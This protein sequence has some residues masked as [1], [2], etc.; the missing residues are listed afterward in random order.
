MGAGHG[1]WLSDS[2]C[3]GF[4]GG[5]M[6]V[7]THLAALHFHHDC[8]DH[9]LGLITQRNSSTLKIL[10]ISFSQNV[11]DSSAKFIVNCQSLTE[12]DIIGTSLSGQV[13]RFSF[14]FSAKQCSEGYLEF[15][16][17]SVN[18]E[19]VK[20]QTANCKLQYRNLPPLHRDAFC[21]FLFRWIYYCYNSKSTGKETGKT[22]LCALCCTVYTFT[23]V[24]NHFLIKYSQSLPI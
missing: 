9:L 21:Q 5:S 16:M 23:M 3:N 15:K 20:I 8:T 17:N 19:S 7:F 14:P 1:G 11:S 24:C 13:R 6:E 18:Y 4:Y 22:H 2:F 12:L 10:D